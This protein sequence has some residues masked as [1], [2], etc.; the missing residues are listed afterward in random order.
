MDA[1]K[2]RIVFNSF[3]LLIII[4]ASGYNGAAQ[5]IQGIWSGTVRMKQVYTGELG[6]SSLEIVTNFTENTGYGTM[7]YE[8]ELKIGA[9]TKEVKCNGAG[10]AT[11]YHLDISKDDDTAD[12]YTYYI[13]VIG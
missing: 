11:L 9:E 5:S 8:G 7:K 2:N 12:I 3:I 6:H 13:H 4:L 1:K 10:N